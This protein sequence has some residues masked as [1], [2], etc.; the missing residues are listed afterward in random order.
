MRI[1]TVRGMIDRRI[2]VNY[3]VDP[4]VLAKFLPDPFRPKLINGQGMAGICLIRLKSLRPRFLPAFLGVSS[5]NAAHRFAVE[6]DEAGQTGQGVYIPRRDTSSRF[7]VLVGGRLFPG[8][9]HYA[10]FHVVEQ[11]G[12]FLID[13]T[14][15]DGTHLR[16][17]GTAADDLPAGS[18]FGDLQQASNFFKAGSRGYSVTPKAGEFDGLELDTFNWQVQP[19]AVRKVVS[20]FFENE[21]I[22]PAGSIE[23]DCALLMQHLDHEWHELPSLCGCQ[24]KKVTTSHALAIDESS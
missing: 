20:T 9:H 15:S 17:E 11:N 3:R 19:L 24:E 6:W 18:I 1:P 23:F 21:K 4:D 8:M 14:S 12:D 13:M 7:N 2:L 16:V 5:E 10:K 22:F